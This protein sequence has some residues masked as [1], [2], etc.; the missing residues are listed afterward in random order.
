MTGQVQVFPGLPNPSNGRTYNLQVG[1][2][3]TPDSAALA[4]LQIKNAGFYVSGEF[5][6]GA[7]RVVV[8]NIPSA[9][10][11]LAVQRLASLGF[12]QIWV[13]EQSPAR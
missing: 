6:G 10:V 13:R 7:Y 4:A 9:V 2:F 12:S 11:Y 5:S 1:S 8:V 3:A